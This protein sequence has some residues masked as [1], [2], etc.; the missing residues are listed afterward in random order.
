MTSKSVSP[1]LHRRHE[2]SE[3]RQALRRSISGVSHETQATGQD[4]PEERLIPGPVHE[5]YDGGYKDWMILGAVYNR[6]LQT[7]LTAQGINVLDGAIAAAAARDIT[8]DPGPIREVCDAEHFCGREFMFFLRHFNFLALSSYG[9]EL[10]GGTLQPETVERFLRER[11]NYFEMD[12]P[13]RALFGKKPGTWPRSRHV[14]SG[15]DAAGLASRYSVTGFP[16][17]C[18]DRRMP[19]TACG[20]NGRGN[21]G[22]Q[23]RGNGARDQVCCR[24]RHRNTWRPDAGRPHN[25]DR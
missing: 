25:L 16:R 13:H 23:K 21:G 15:G 6:L 20:R 7:K 1:P 10:A 12:L 3:A 2:S 9:F 11:L 17:R 18:L 24:W 19:Q 22:R 4:S 8:N 5:L 14:D